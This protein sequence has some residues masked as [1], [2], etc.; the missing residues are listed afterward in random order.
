[1][2]KTSRIKT[3]IIAGI[4]SAVTIFSVSTMAIGSASAKSLDTKEITKDLTEFGVEKIIDATVGDGIFG[5]LLNKG[6]GYILGMAFDNDEP[7][8]AGVLLQGSY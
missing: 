5:E 7:G 2:K 4:L 3:R 1:M 8:I 6:A